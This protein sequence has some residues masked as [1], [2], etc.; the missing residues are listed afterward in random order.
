[1]NSSLCNPSHSWFCLL[2][3]WKFPLMPLILRHLC[4]AAT[5]MPSSSHGALGPLKLPSPSASFSFSPHL[6]SSILC[7]LLP[8]LPHGCCPHSTC[9]LTLYQ[10]S[11]LSGALP[12]FGHKNPLMGIFPSPANVDVFYPLFGLWHL[13]LSATHTLHLWLLSCHSP[14]P[15]WALT[16]CT[17]PLQS[18]LIQTSSLMSWPQYKPFVLN[19][20]GKEKSEKESIMS[21][22]IP[23]TLC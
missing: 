16:H 13:H 8:S 6:G 23:P 15:T 3:M 2:L 20:S 9:A 14:R 18:V 11:L 22:F 1:M 21:L 12:H 19:F 10:A 5:T 7:W 17:L 4:R